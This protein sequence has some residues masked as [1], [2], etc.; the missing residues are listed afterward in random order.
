MAVE[1]FVSFFHPD[2]IYHR[3][4]RTLQPKLKYSSFSSNSCFPP[5]VRRGNCHSEVCV[6]PSS[7]GSH[8]STKYNCICKQ[9]I[10]FVFFK[11]HLDATLYPLFCNL[12]FFTQHYILN[13]LSSSFSFSTVIFVPIS[14]ID[15]D[16]LILFTASF[17]FLSLC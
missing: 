17:S 11:F 10:V 3:R 16:F 4:K 15:F 13:V 7:S 5:S 12:L 9:S 14:D 2:F 8:M 6:Y 1:V